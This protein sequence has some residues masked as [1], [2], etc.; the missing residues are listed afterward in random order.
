[1]SEIIFSFENSQDAQL[2]TDIMKKADPSL[3]CV[4]MRSVVC[5][6]SCANIITAAQAVM[7]ASIPCSFR[8]WNDILNEK[9]LSQ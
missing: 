8:Y 2:A 6:I 3:L 5:V 1:M 7:D 4:Q 9:Y